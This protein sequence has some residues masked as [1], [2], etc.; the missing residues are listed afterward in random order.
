M[1][2]VALKF[3]MNC[4]CWFSLSENSILVEI[5]YLTN[6]CPFSDWN[7]MMYNVS[8]TYRDFKTHEYT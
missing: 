5:L 2:S 3:M 4:I 8:G 6:H 7:I 1:Y